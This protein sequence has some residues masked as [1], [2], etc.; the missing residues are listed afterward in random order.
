[1][2]TPAS[3]NESRP[4]T[5]RRI[6]PFN[7][8]VGEYLNMA[9]EEVTIWTDG[10][11]KEWTNERDRIDDEIK[12]IRERIY[13]T[14]G[15]G[16]DM[17]ELKD[18]LYREWEDQSQQLSQL[19]RTIEHQDMLIM[20]RDYYRVEHGLIEQVTEAE[21]NNQDLY[22]AVGSQPRERIVELILEGIF[23]M[24]IDVLSGGESGGGWSADKGGSGAGD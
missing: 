16:D 2:A 13:A 9:A 5:G 1:M 8:N 15:T 20:W 6:S 10:M 7:F 22:E 21:Q 14:R 18:E 11:R 23:G 17:K 3:Q 24:P 19:G 12:K 4:V